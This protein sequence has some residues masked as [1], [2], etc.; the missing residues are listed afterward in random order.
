MARTN[1]IA[2][3]L[4]LFAMV[5]SSLLVSNT[6]STKVHSSSKAKLKLKGKASMS[7]D[8]SG[9]VDTS[10]VGDFTDT[11]DW[12][13]FLN[14]SHNGHPTQSREEATSQMVRDDADRDVDI[15]DSFA[16]FEQDDKTEQQ[17][18][19]DQNSYAPL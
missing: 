4:C 12:T 19:E 10:V 5:T 9:A 2:V 16:E 18:V 8:L 6:A 15:S 7:R 14:V 1:V 11:E 13:A 3:A 17:I